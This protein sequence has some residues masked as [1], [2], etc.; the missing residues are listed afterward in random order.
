MKETIALH[1]ADLVLTETEL[2]ALTASVE[3]SLAARLPVKPLYLI[4]SGAYK[5][6]YFLRDHVNLILKFSRSDQAATDKAKYQQIRASAAK[7]FI[8]PTAFIPLP[9][10]ITLN[11]LVSPPCKYCEL[12]TP[13]ECQ[14]PMRKWIGDTLIVQRRVT[15]LDRT[16]Y[17]N[18]LRAQYYT[19]EEKMPRAIQMALV[20]TSDLARS[21]AAQYESK[22]N[23]FQLDLMLARYG[24][25]AVIDAVNAFQDADLQDISSYNTG[26]TEAGDF[27]I[28]D[29][30]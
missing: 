22:L 1:T 27:I 23:P 29:W 25:Q 16:G 4:R 5:E 30:L 21:L 20:P 10:Y 15:P 14:A 17:R 19:P 3:K 7:D 24:D 28:F 26:L 12:L 6:S 2:A 18:A 8:L 13:Q 11:N 9:S